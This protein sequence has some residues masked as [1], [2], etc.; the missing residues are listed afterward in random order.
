MRLSPLIY[1]AMIAF[2]MT[3]AQAAEYFV[4]TQGSD[5]KAGLTADDA[6]ATVQ[7][8]L[9]ALKP[10]DTLTILPG[11]YYGVAQRKGLGDAEVDTVIRAQIPGTAVLRGDVEVGPFQPVPNRK[12]VFVADYA[13]EQPVQAVNELDTVTILEPMPSVDEL[14]FV[15][16]GFHHDTMAGK[17]Y[18][19]TTDYQPAAAHRYSVSNTPR[20]GILLLEP[21]RVIIEGLTFRGFNAKFQQPRVDM[22][23]GG[24]WGLF[25]AK[26]ARC[27]VRDC[28]AFL[29]GQGIGMHSAV[30]QGGTWGGNLIERCTVWGNG[31]SFT[32]GDSGGI[33][34]FESA[35]DVIRDCVAFRNHH[36]G[37][38]LYLGH[39]A[40]TLA[41][42]ASRIINNLAVHNH[43]ADLKI[44]T[45]DDSAH[46]T[47]GN[48]AGRPTNDVDPT[49]SLFFQVTHTMGVL[50]S[51]NIRLDQEKSLDPDREFA[52]PMNFDFRLQATSRF[53]GNAEDGGDRGPAAYAANIYYVAPD[54]SDDA[55]G[56]SVQH[57][58]R[59]VDRA[60]K[61]LKPGDT[62]YLL[63]GPYNATVHISLAGEESKPIHIRGR[64]R[65]DVVLTGEAQITN[66][67]FVTLERLQF[68]TP[69]RVIDSHHLTLSQSRF[70]GLDASGSSA[71]E[72]RHNE[73]SAPLRLTRCSD[74]TVVGNRFELGES[75]AMEV[76]ALD[77][78][79]FAGYNGYSRA[80]S[81]W[82]VGGKPASV[83]PQSP[84][85]G[86]QGWPVGRYR[87]EPPVV[88]PRV[89]DGPVLHSVSD[90]TANIEWFTSLPAE[91]TLAWGDTA[92][93]KQTATIEVDHF[94]T[95]SITGLEPGKRYYFQIRSLAIPPY[96]TTQLG[97][98]QSPHDAAPLAFTTASTGS[99][100]RTWYVAH[101][102]DDQQ[103]G[104]SRATAWR[105]LGH[106]AGRV[107]VGD[108]V[109]IAGGVYAERVRLR[110]TGAP[111]APITF[112]A[113]PGEKVVL[114]GGDKQLTQGFVANA[115]SHL[116]FD[117]LYFQDFNAFPLQ[118]WD[119]RLSGEISLYCGRDA[120][121]TR[122]FSDG[123]NG[124]TARFI[125]AFD[126]SDMFVQNCVI[127]DKMSGGMMWNG[128]PGLR[129][130]HCAS[131]RSMTANFVLRNTS[132]QLAVFTRNVF[133]DA[134]KKKA[135]NN[136][137]LFVVDMEV[138]GFR[139]IDNA[140][141]LRSQPLEQRHLV[142]EEPIGNLSSHIINPR[143]VNPRF[144]GDP[145]DDG[146]G[147]DDH[148]GIDRMTNRDAAI[149]FPSFFV[150]DPDLVAAGIGLQ[151]DAFKDFHFNVHRH[152]PQPSHGAT[153]R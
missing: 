141:F 152:E 88:A 120:R 75:A 97:D 122:C 82:R 96:L 119:R 4:G 102:G 77:A 55:D 101:D 70:H 38:N 91:C 123:R 104:H 103:T 148:R 9:D 144:A 45:G 59:S 73:F 114:S 61:A 137:S 78:M 84:P 124:Y 115:K 108:T 79:R 6:F 87:I 66:S 146:R 142:N 139:M 52:D 24:T 21:K 53:R 83:Q 26:P 105:T 41:E 107:G 121:I 100:P 3:S 34:I 46:I 51:D 74:T 149:D 10:G 50:A 109:L 116:R 69:V 112:A 36:Y 31:S 118:G 94:G 25:L 71:M 7:R 20:H 62:L 12:F 30:S 150:T 111:D 93:C 27:V 39:E 5:E 85:A 13:L 99:E 135:D 64:G 18:I 58:W 92:D 98:M 125:S 151:P 8:G 126:F 76:D 153:V 43:P 145:G 143:F 127:I 113:M 128:C 89:V 81:A 48:V 138:G 17:L 63:P 106:A 130:E 67:H 15:P 14:A 134:L 129:V 28:H 147:Q 54:G 57:A 60:I 40:S 110:A 35:R 16:G 80:A 1:S 32:G 33:T 117:G 65:A 49:R 68:R 86:P 132:E 131:V 42:N 23:L 95:Y 19:S 140:Y 72:V 56:L 29:N 2:S 133:T 22:S 47:S 37:I 11:E 90:T 136:V 44:K